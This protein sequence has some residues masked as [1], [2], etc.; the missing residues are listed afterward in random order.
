MSKRRLEE[1]IVWARE[2]H[3]EAADLCIDAPVNPGLEELEEL[4][5]VAED[6]LDRLYRA[7]RDSLAT[8]PRADRGRR[9]VSGVSEG[10]SGDLRAAGGENNPEAESGLKT[11]ETGA[12]GAREPIERWLTADQCSAPAQYPYLDEFIAD[13]VDIH[14]E[15]MGDAQFWMSA[16]CRDTGRMWHLNFGAVS[17]RVKGYAIATDATPHPRPSK[18]R[19]EGGGE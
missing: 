17:T 9:S 3:R 6:V 15:A 16:T 1:T 12:Q 2:A 4:A 8:H 14:F 11:R 18:D 5:A 7:A 10:V 19:H 13:N